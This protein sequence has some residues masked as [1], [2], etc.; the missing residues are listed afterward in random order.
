M[1]RELEFGIQWLGLLDTICIVARQL[2][3]W[4]FQSML[5][6]CDLALSCCSSAIL[7]QTHYHAWPLWPSAPSFEAQPMLPRD[8]ET[9]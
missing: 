2:C 1:V 5:G 8:K 7:G 9:P 3:M 4:C 6:C